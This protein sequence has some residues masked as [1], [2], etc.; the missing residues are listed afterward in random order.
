MICVEGYPDQL[1]ERFL[2]EAGIQIEIIR[3]IRHEVPVLQQ[4]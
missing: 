4:P 3:G 2:E 1:T